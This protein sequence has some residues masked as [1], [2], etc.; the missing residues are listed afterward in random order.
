MT[1]WTAALQDPLF[2]RI[3]SNSSEW[4][5]N[6]F[7]HSCL[8]PLIHTPS[9]VHAKS[10][11]FCLTLCDPM[12]CSLPDSSIH[13]I[14]QARI[15]ECH[16]ALLQGISWPRDWSCLSYVSCIGRW[17]LLLL[18]LPGKPCYTPV[19]PQPSSLSP[20]VSTSLFSIFMSLFL[21]CY[22]H[23]LYSTYRW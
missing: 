21:S 23:S 22:V 2:F 19:F 1:L 10:L 18:A 4:L 11:Q 3:C 9:C 7:I 5:S 20:L 14:V 17:V 13:G 6:H 8:Y 16:Y 12:N 15:L